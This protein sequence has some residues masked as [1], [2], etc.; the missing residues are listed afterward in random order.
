MNDRAFCYDGDVCGASTYI[1]D[2]GG[3]FVGRQN[4]RAESGRQAL[5]HHKYLAYMG[6]LSGIKK[7][8]LLDVRDA[9][10]PFQVPSSP[11]R[12]FYRNAAE[13]RQP[14]IEV[15]SHVALASA[16]QLTAA[17]T[18]SPFSYRSFESSG[19]S[20]EGRPLPGIPRHWLS[21]EL[22][23]GRP[24]ARGPWLS[25]EEQYSSSMTV[26]D[27]LDARAP[28]W[29]T[30]HVRCGWDGA[31]AGGRWSPYVAVSNVFD[32]RY[33]S[34]VAINAS[35]GRYYEPAPRRTLYAGVSLSAG[36]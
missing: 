18:F 30:T 29:W 4:T 15:G 22:H 20:L 23:A 9:L 13:T 31:L 7:C 3:P 17:W 6:V 32:R 36:R 25:L 2:R 26:A 14:G 24:E 28:E 12:V 34:S 8:P 16:A 33:V 5:F 11:G 1:Y 35:F 21:V 19:R 10:V 27:T